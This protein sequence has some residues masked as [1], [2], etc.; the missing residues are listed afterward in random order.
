[1]AEEREGRSTN[2]VKVRRC[3]LPG[4]CT[5]SLSV[6]V[7]LFILSVRGDLSFNA[8]STY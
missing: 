4:F 3:V 1:M 7:A 5:S 8:S 2:E 6:V